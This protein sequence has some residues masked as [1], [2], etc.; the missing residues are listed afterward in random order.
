MNKI[1]GVL[2]LLFLFVLSGK[3]FPQSEK[4]EMVFVEGGSF[5]LGCTAIQ[6]EGCDKTSLPVSKVTLKSFYIGKYEVTQSLWIT[7]MGQNDAINEENDYPASFISWY[8][9]IEFCNLLSERENL[10]QVYT[11]DKS[12]KDPNNTGDF[13]EVMWTV[14]ADFTKNGYR[15]PTEAEWEFAARGGNKSEG[16]LYPGSDDPTEI[17]NYETESGALPIGK[18]KANE[19]GLFDMG[20]NVREWCS[21]W[22][23]PY[24]V[25]EKTNPRGAEKGSAKITRGGSW[26]DADFNLRVDNRYPLIP[27]RAFPF[28]GFRLARNAD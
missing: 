12:K 28:T 26:F 3:L 9:A 14:T 18:K 1:A 13:D 19:L 27:D 7:I 23:A 4:Y 16:F 5:S 15:L 25:S 2:F 20:G 8:Q 21:D 6:S 11:I 10:Q 17:G 24:S 22:D